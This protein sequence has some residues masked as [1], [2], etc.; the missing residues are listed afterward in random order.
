[1]RST[2]RRNKDYGIKDTYQIFDLKDK[3]DYETYS[4]I[5]KLLNQRFMDNMILDNSSIMIPYLG[6]IKLE[7]FK[8]KFSNPKR[9]P[10][11]YG[12][13]LKVW[14]SKYGMLS[15]ADFKKI[16]DKPLIR[17]DNAHTDGYKIKLV[18]DK[19]ATDM[20]GKYGYVFLMTRAHRR[21]LAKK[22]KEGSVDF[23]EKVGYV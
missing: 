9:M 13:T 6:K 11:D 21:F 18:W 4:K 2:G 23:Y 12:A 10:L 22:L 19:T 7:K 20:K 17:Q 8:P 5:C 15:M 3:I 14:R 16:K 1:M